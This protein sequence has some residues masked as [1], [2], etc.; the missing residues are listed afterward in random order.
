MLEVVVKVMVVVVVVVAEMAV[1]TVAVEVVIVCVQV[2]TIFYLFPI[3][4]MGLR[5]LR[6]QSPQTPS[7]FSP[8]CS[9]MSAEAGAAK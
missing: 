4:V 9:S 3:L 2:P 6:K 7:C 5:A 8:P 1:V